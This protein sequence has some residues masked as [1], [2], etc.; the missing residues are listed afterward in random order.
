MLNIQGLINIP[1]WKGE[2]K[3]AIVA[4]YVPTWLLVL[5]W[6][7]EVEIVLEKKEILK[8]TKFPLNREFQRKRTAISS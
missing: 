7:R 5:D 8:Q 3:R 2:K 4:S 1:L 6:G